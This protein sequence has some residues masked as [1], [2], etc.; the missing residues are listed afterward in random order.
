MSGEVGSS[1]S[2]GVRSGTTRLSDVSRRPFR[3]E[4][5]F[6]AGIDDFVDQMSAFIAE[7]VA[8]GE[9]AL[10]VVSAEKI[11]RLQDALG[12]VPE[13]VRFADMAG[14]G[15]NPARI[16]PAWRDF[17]DEQAP[18]GAPFRGV[19]E[20]IWAQRSAAE[21]VECQRHESLLNLAFAEETGFWLACPY[22]T[23]T[24][25]AAVLDEAK[26][27]HPF[28]SER[29]VESPSS[30][31]AGVEAISQPFAAPLPEVPP[32]AETLTITASH[33]AELRR[34]VRR[35]ASAAGFSDQA[36][37]DL[38]LVANEIATNSIRHGGGGGVFRIWREGS[39]LVCE[40][41]DAGRIVHAM[42]GRER[43]VATQGNGLGL[44][45]ANQ[46]C[47]LVQIR[48]FDDGSVVRLRIS[49]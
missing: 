41:R 34:L 36:S 43:P 30:I 12:G 9:P 19:G 2:G 42:V 47:D 20:P 8:R 5:R 16:I 10:V 4:A 18:A 17:V 13:G 22:D 40:M 39:A 25:P 31:Y 35:R 38:V 45:L 26:R 44:W 6:Y 27:S 33:L 24:L 15:L 23:T 11:E 37:G 32:D 7:G 1:S 14:V 29:R 48:T 46:L 21:L 3:H 49:A 28:V